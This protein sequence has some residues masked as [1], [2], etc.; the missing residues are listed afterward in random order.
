MISRRSLITGAIAT[1]TTL[2]AFSNRARVTAAEWLLRSAAENDEPAGTPYP[3]VALPT[4]SPMGQVYE[5]PPNYETPMH[6]LI[7]EKNYPFTD[8]DYY[9]VRYREAMPPQFDWTDYRLKIT[10]DA[11][12]NPTELAMTDLLEFDTKTIAAVGECSGL[13]RG[14]IR[15]LIPGMPWTK[16]DVSCAQWTGA[17]IRDVV[18]SCGV[19]DSAKMIHLRSGASTVAPKKG[20]YI[21]SY[22]V[23][24]ILTDDA[25]LAWRQNGV[26]LNFWNG[27]PLRVVVPGTSAPRWVKQIVEIEVSS[28]PNP[29]EWSGRDIGPGKLKTCSLITNPPDGTKVNAGE[30]VALKGVAWDA[31]QG[32][33]KVEVTADGGQTWQEADLEEQVDKYAWR[34]FNAEVTVESTGVNAFAARAT[35]TDGS[36]QPWEPEQEVLDNGARNNNASETFSLYL[37]GV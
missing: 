22:L 13:G 33:E 24:D 16:G 6:K 28:E 21:R 10:G 15:P 26:A 17:S 27:Y 36:T 5:L 34:V 12:E 37:M 35:S 25:I 2:V 20:D 9:Y 23:E 4:K 7:G 1:A 29:H 18:E 32:I 30:T 19:K 31:G 11:I 8:N 3:L 14:L